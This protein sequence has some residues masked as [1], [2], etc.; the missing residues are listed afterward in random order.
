VPREDLLE[1]NSKT[2]ATQSV[3]EIGA[4]GIGGWLVQLLSG[5]G[6]ILIDAVSFLA[7]V[8]RVRARRQT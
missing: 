3:S 1:A 6:A 7:P 5:P 2:A 8:F 4:F